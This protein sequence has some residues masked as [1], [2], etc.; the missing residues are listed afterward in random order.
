MCSPYLD[1]ETLKIIT[2]RLKGSR[3][4][5]VPGEG[6][7][8]LGDSW[9]PAGRLSPPSRVPWGREHLTKP[10]P[11][12]ARDPQVRKAGLHVT[13]GSRNGLFLFPPPSFESL[14]FPVRC[15]TVPMEVEASMDLGGMGAC[16]KKRGLLLFLGF[17]PWG[18]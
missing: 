10:A 17:S 5:R 9:G 1:F 14:I 16:K 6:G 11:G 3:R 4:A 13:A 8:N 12:R 18:F 7:S 15:H 2:C